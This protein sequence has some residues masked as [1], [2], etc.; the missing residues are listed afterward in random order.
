M[1]N[2]QLGM[3]LSKAKQRGVSPMIVPVYCLERDYRLQGNRTQSE[4]SGLPE[5]RRQSPCI[6]EP[7]AARICRTKITRDKRATE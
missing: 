2:R 6:R 7:K 5:L 3:S 1:E 4:P